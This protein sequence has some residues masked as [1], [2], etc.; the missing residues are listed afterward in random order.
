M[1][2]FELS[3]L[4]FSF[5]NNLSLFGY[6]FMKYSAEMNITCSGGFYVGMAL[7]YNRGLVGI[8]TR[9]PVFLLHIL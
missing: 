2:I 6:N 8:F 3:E 7:I 1:I 4:M 5:A 9:K